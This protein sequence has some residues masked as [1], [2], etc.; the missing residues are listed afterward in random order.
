[1]KKILFSVLDQ[2]VTG[3]AFNYQSPTVQVVHPWIIYS[4]PYHL[5]LRKQNCYLLCSS[6]LPV[7]LVFY[8]CFVVKLKIQLEQSKTPQSMESDTSLGKVN[9]LILGTKEIK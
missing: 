2:V 6:D 3:H 5:Y 9:Q 4:C 8:L 7:V 1:M